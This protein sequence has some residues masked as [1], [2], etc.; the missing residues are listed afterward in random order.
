MLSKKLLYLC[1][2][3]LSSVNRTPNDIYFMVVLKELNELMCVK[4]VEDSL[5][6]L[7][8]IN[9][10]VSIVKIAMLLFGSGIGRALNGT[11]WVVLLKGTG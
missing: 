9:G 1:P 8:F 6:P 4:C 3:V 2:S 5:V 7:G 10:F 11:S